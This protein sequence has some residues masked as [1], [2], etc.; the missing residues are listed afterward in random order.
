[1]KC[2]DA[3]VNKSNNNIYL[4]LVYEL[5]QYIVY[6]NNLDLDNLY[7]MNADKNLYYDKPWIDDYPTNN[8]TVKI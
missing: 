8:I 4:N 7:Q 6:I 3:N 5:D 1:M 2:I